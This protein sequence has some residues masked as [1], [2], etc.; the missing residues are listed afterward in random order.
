MKN[1]L[2]ICEQCNKKAVVEIPCFNSNTGESQTCLNCGWFVSKD[3]LDEEELED[4]RENNNSEEFEILKKEG[5]IEISKDY[6]A[7]KWIQKTIFPLK[8][9]IL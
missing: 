2:K 7:K 5:I 9:D 1:T 8:D 6:E 4:L 3:Y